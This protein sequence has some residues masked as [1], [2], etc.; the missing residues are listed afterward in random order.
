MALSDAHFTIRAHHGAGLRAWRFPHEK[1]WLTKAAQA[2][3][4]P[5]RAF[6][7]LI[8]PLYDSFAGI[9]PGSTR[10]A[11]AGRYAGSGMGG[12]CCTLWES[13]KVAVGILL[14]RF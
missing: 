14:R 5:E 6:S 12:V 8:L 9:E 1:S 10:S 11:R 3:H 2:R 13:V 4:P 7:I